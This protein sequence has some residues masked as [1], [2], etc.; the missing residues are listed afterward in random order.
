MDSCKKEGKCGE[1][2]ML[3]GY[4]FCADCGA[5][6]IFMVDS[7]FQR[8]TLLP[9]EKAFAY[10]MRL[11]AMK[12]QG[13]RTDLTSCPV[14]TKLRS[15]ETLAEKT[16]DSA[17]Q[18]QR[19]ICLTA[20]IPALLQMVDEGKIAFRPAVELSYL[21]ENE[22]ADLLE[23]MEAEIA[24]PSLAQAIKMKRFSQEGKLTPEVIQSILQEEKP[25]QVEQFK[26]PMAK[27][28]RFFAP[29]T[30]AQKKED[31]IVKALEQYR[32]RQRD[33]ER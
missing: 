7:N 33:K 18:V 11:D 4:I 22:Q 17:R 10:K 29:G 21:Q 15:D 19:Y 13:R 14:G 1:V 12:R 31:I 24:T 3:A 32:K 2:H 5:A 6:M 25:N 20:L 23:A 8:E 27:I 26:I 16:D 30:P 28:D 9:S